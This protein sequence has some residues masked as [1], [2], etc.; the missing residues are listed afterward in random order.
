[1]KFNPSILSG[2][3][4]AYIRRDGDERGIHYSNGKRGPAGEIRTAA[5]SPDG[6]QVVFHKRVTFQR[7]PWVKTW[8][9]NPQYE[10][11]LTNGGPSFSPTGDR[12]AFVG[13]AEK[14]KG[15]GVMV[16]NVGGETSQVVY[17]DPDAQR[18]R[19]PVVRRTATGSSLASASSMRSSTDF[20][21]CS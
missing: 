10:L 14:A 11:T 4:L 3:V 16:A 15:A 7:K 12:F 20:T 21:V 13:P 2:D 5:W 17:R 18:A 9:R 19:T 6:T 8:S 1:M